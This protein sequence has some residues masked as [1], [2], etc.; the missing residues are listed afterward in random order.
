MSNKDK[1]SQK[2]MEKQL[3][4][5]FEQ[6]SNE[7]T[8]SNLD[9]SIM[10]MAQKQL[11]QTQKVD[12]PLSWWL[13]LSKRSFKYPMSIAAALF[14]T[15]GI[16]RFMAHLSGTDVSLA[17]KPELVMATEQESVE[18]AYSLETDAKEDSAL[19]KNKKIESPQYNE[20]KAP[21]AIKVE[22]AEARSA[23]K[24]VAEQQK[25]ERQ[26]MEQQKIEAPEDYAKVQELLAKVRASSDIQQNQPISSNEKVV[27]TGSRIKR[28]DVE[29]ATPVVSSLSE[30]ATASDKSQDSLADFEGGTLDEGVMGHPLPEIWT[31]QIEQA[32]E[33]GDE[34]KALDE[35]GQFRRT[36]PDYKVDD[37]LLE[38]IKS[39]QKLGKSD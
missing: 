23:K 14:V 4:Q 10:Q 3:E 34:I 13:K 7:T 22:E 28:A 12:K 39:L 29:S 24:L 32:I 18:I 1:A 36:Y 20:L 16:A 17:Q 15:V 8:D 11:E 30:E 2:A 31:E 26:E 35:W 38:K 9:A 25:M 5:L 33:E 37:F 19:Q 21:A 27:I 6:E